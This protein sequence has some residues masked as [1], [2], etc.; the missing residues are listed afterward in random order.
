MR[1]WK[2]WVPSEARVR[3]GPEG[4]PG[5]PVVHRGWAVVPGRVGTV[6]PGMGCPVSAAMILS[7]LR[8]MTDDQLCRWVTARR[9][10]YSGAEA[11][12]LEAFLLELPFNG[13]ALP[14]HL[15][16]QKTPAGTGD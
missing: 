1:W 6:P 4:H 10:C 12:A 8:K 5:C 15:F 14:A 16:Q 13:R 9:G 7:R 3:Y 2:G 11:K